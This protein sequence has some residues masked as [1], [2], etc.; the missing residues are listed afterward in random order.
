MSKEL[1]GSNN[2]AGKYNNRRTC[3]NY[4]SVAR[5][6]T[7]YYQF[8]GKIKRL[9]AAAGEFEGTLDKYLPAGKRAENV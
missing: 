2:A 6:N 7:N 4:S 1:R 5:A 3:S 8:A 9:A